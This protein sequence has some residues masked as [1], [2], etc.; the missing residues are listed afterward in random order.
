VKKTDLSAYSNPRAGGIIALGLEEGDRLVS[1]LVTNGDEEVLLGTKKGLVIRFPEANVRPMGRTAY[2]VKGIELES[3]DEVISMEVVHRR[4]GATLLTVTEHGYGKRTDLGEYRTQ[5]RG[6]KGIITIQTTPRNGDVV[7]VLQVDPEADVML[8]TAG[9][10]VLRLT[11]SALRVIGR[12]T[13]G[14]RLIEMGQGDRVAAAAILREKD[15][16]APG[17][18]DSGAEPTNS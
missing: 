11:V 10:Q 14:V 8:V 4:E 3:G 5:S 6:G 16:T 18:G 9:A 13:Q 2:G 15:E 1:A 17:N 12:N 7:A